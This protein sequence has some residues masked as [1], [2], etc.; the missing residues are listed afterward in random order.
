MKEFF[1]LLK[2]PLPVNDIFNL[3]LSEDMFLCSYSS[4]VFVLIEVS[5]NIIKHYSQVQLICIFLWDK[6]F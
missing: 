3:K 2:I 4:R 6:C 1:S 5:N